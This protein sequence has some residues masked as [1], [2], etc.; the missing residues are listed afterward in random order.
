MAIEHGRGARGYAGLAISVDRQGRHLAPTPNACTATDIRHAD[1]AAVESVIEFMGTLPALWC[2]CS[3][4]CLLA[5]ASPCSSRVALTRTTA[6][7]AGWI[8]K[9]RST[10]NIATTRGRRDQR[11]TKVPKSKGHDLWRDCVNSRLG[12][13]PLHALAASSSATRR[14]SLRHSGAQPQTP[15]WCEQ[16]PRCGPLHVQVGESVSSQQSSGRSGRGGGASAIAADARPNTKAMRS[17]SAPSF[18]GMIEKDRR[19]C[20]SCA[21]PTGMPSHRAGLHPGGSLPRRL[22]LW[23]RPAMIGVCTALCREEMAYIHGH[24]AC[25]RSGCPMFGVNQAECCDGETAEAAPVRTSE[26]AAAPAGRVG[27][28]STNSGSGRPR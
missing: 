23:P 10:G 4:R 3:S 25:V 27:A 24:A 21:S 22:S 11:S 15:L 18:L 14:S 5:R 6:A 9:G 16:Q 17:A 13:A 2:A 1:L 19:S 8:A 28:R 20:A 26:I 7:R 12:V